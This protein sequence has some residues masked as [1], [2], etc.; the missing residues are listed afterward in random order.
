VRRVVVRIA[1]DKARED[2]ALTVVGIANL[3]V[4]LGVIV[5]E[6]LHQ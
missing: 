4:F 2:M 6:E 3:G 5:E 1:P